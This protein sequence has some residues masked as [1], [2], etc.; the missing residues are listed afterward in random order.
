ML[1]IRY[2]NFITYD[3]VQ[4]IQYYA[5]IK[6][7]NWTSIYMQIHHKHFRNINWLHIRSEEDVDPAFEKTRKQLYHEYDRRVVTV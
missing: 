5:L 2:D 4:L 3:P 1:S 6:Y 7:H